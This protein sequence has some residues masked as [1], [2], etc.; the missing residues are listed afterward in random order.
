ML[1]KAMHRPRESNAV[2]MMQPASVTAATGVVGF[3]SSEASTSTA[4][5]EMAGW[6]SETRKQGAAREGKEL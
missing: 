5:V 4:N 1:G 3:M 2:E 6:E